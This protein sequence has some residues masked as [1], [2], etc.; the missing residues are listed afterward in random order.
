VLA[1]RVQTLPSLESQLSEDAE[2][3]GASRT[4]A[5]SGLARVTARRV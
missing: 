1:G 2:G 3:V 5:D 4:R